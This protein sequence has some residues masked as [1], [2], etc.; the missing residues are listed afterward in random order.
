MEENK[1]LRK[2]TSNYDTPDQSG[3][4]ESDPDS[5][6]KAVLNSTP[7][8]TQGWQS[9]NKKILSNSLTEEAKYTGQITHYFSVPAK[10]NNSDI[11]VQPPGRKSKPSTIHEDQ[12]SEHEMTEK[13]E[14]PAN[15]KKVNENKRQTEDPTKDSEII[16]Q[17]FQNKNKQVQFSQ[18]E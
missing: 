8:P 5:S 4:K 18:N 15:Q 2:N 10:P 13:H 16:G 17:L 14:N 12:E 9:N 7:I 11:K 3:D 6:Q 1:H